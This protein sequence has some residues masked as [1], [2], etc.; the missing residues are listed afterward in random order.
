MGPP[1]QPMEHPVNPSRS[2]KPT[3]WADL[4]PSSQ[5]AALD[6]IHAAG[7]TEQPTYSVACFARIVSASPA[8]ILRRIRSRQIS[9]LRHGRLIRVPIAEVARLLGL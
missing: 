9:A 3:P 4:S 2:P 6:L 7:L 1:N 8:T 5:Q